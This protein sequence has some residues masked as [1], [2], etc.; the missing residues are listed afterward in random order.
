MLKNTHVTGIAHD[1]RNS[2]RYT[3]RIDADGTFVMETTAS[4]KNGGNPNDYRWVGVTSSTRTITGNIRADG[5]YSEAAAGLYVNSV[6]RYG[7]R[8]NGTPKGAWIDFASFV[9]RT[10]KYSD[11]EWNGETAADRER[12]A[13][14]MVAQKV[15]SE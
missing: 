13:T 1:G 4:A 10:L 7:T 9:G 2:R 12:N 11:G 14:A 6:S 15:W 8:A 3:I 5:R